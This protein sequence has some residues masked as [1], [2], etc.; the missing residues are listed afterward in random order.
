MK[1]TPSSTSR[2]APYRK[3]SGPLALQASTPPMVRTSPP[4]GSSVRRWRAGD[5]RIPSAPSVMP[6]STL[7][8]MSSATYSVM[9]SSRDRSSTRSSRRGRLPRPW[10][11]P[12]PRGATAS[13]SDVARARRRLTSSSVRARTTQR[14]TTPSTAAASTARASARTC[15]GPTMSTSASRSAGADTAI[16]LGRPVPLD[17]G[18]ARQARSRRTESLA[19]GRMGRQELA[20]VHDSVGIEAPP[21]AEHEVEIRVAILLGHALGLVEAD[22]VLAGHA[23]AEAQTR[24]HQLVVD[25]L[26]TLRLARHAIVIEDHRMQVAVT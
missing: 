4:Y 18:S 1:R 5:R 11:D 3:R 26:G 23:A 15:A 2:P 24:R 16:A 19:A 6:A 14:G 12:L 10:L 22:A 20:G 25:L 8:T 21:E 13:R 17:P 7:A 9:A